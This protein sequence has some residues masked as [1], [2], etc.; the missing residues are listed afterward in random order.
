MFRWQGLIRCVAFRFRDRYCMD[1][2][3][4]SDERCRHRE[5]LVL[6][7]HDEAASFLCI[8]GAS[9]LHGQ[10]SRH[11]RSIFRLGWD[12]GVILA[13]MRFLDVEHIYF[14]RFPY[15]TTADIMCTVCSK[16]YTVSTV[17]ERQPGRGV[18]LLNSMAG[19]II[20]RRRTFFLLDHSTFYTS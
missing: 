3:S 8:S 15:D 20:N 11:T 12:Q 9:H 14:H 5:G 13:I 4:V 7:L 16:S 1:C 19:Q 6:L 18:R 2:I 17:G 10:V